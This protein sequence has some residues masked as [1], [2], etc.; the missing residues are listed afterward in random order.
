M[1]GTRRLLGSYNLGSMAN[2]MPQ[3]LG[4]QALDRTREVVAF[5]GDGGLTMLMGDL[6]TAVA[7]SLPVRLVVF[8]NGRL[9]MVRLEQEQAGLPEFGTRLGDVDIAAIARATGMHA[10]RVEQSAELDEAVRVAF[11]QPGPALLDIV[12]NPDE[13]SLPPKVKPAQAWGFAIAKLTEVIESR[14]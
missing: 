5:C 1:R 3:A 14:S 13:I 12:T 4:A 11:T 8:N 9:G 7:H 2:A 6:I 10:Q